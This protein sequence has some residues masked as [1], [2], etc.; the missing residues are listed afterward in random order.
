MEREE[1]RDWER[2]KWKEIDKLIR[3]TTMGLKSIP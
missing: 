2:K 1:E 3:V